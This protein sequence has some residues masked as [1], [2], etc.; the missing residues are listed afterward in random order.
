MEELSSFELLGSR[1]F[2][3][4]RSLSTATVEHPHVHAA[5]VG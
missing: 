4:R 5:D 2:T 3:Q 1:V